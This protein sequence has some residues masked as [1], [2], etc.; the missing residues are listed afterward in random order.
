[1]NMELLVLGGYGQ[2]V[3]PAFIFTFVSCFL[4]YIKTKKELKRQEKMFLIEFK[5]M[6]IT[7]IEVAKQ[8]EL[9]KEVL[10]SSPTY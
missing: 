5:Q 6:P 4:L 1:M 2:F 10:S 8:K 9:L 7:K 3:W